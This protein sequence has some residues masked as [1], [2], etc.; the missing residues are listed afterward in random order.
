MSITLSP[1]IA[2]STEEG[3]AVITPQINALVPVPWLHPK[4]G[5]GG[6][7]VS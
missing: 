3:H 7:T 6:K 4:V 1:A 5:K 2:L